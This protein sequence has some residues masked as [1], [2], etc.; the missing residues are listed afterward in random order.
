M[1]D[2]DLDA[3]LHGTLLGD[4]MNNAEVGALLADER[5]QYIA[6]NNLVCELTGYSRKQ[7]TGFRA[8]QLAA[9]AASRG[10][11]EKLM[12]RTKM[13]GRKLVRCKNGLVVPCRYL[14]IP[15]RV[16]HLP[17]VLLLLWATAEPA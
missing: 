8:G 9:D 11:Y 6:A 1:V 12:S 2:H 16:A 5:G 14:G 15:T 7:L 3:V 4:G 13:R 17:Y 10:I